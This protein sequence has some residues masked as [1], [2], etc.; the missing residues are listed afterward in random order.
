MKWLSTPE[1]V[2][3]VLDAPLAIIYKHSTRCAV[4]AAAMREI[5]AFASESPEAPLYAIDVHAGADASN[6]LEDRTDVPHESPQLII[7][8]DGAVAW[9][10]SHWDIRKAAVERH[11]RELRGDTPA[12]AAQ[13][14][15]ELR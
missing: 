6:E 4:S 9:H 7:T 3:A 13:A 1:D 10:A 5:Q 2:S 11:Y 12:A 15:S 14:A 8:S